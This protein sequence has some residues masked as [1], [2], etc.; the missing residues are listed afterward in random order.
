MGQP[1][2]SESLVSDGVSELVN[3]VPAG[4]AGRLAYQ[5]IKW[6]QNYD[7]DDD[8]YNA[9]FEQAAAQLGI[10]YNEF[11]RLVDDY[12]RN[13]VPDDVTQSISTEYWDGIE[14]RPG[15]RER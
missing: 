14:R 3:R 11:I 6:A 1:P 8:A 9:L 12:L 7:Y 2:V 4:D 15:M 10:D 5:A 13:G